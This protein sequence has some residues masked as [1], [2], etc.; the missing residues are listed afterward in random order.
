MTRK[1]VAPICYRCERSWGGGYPAAM[2]DRL[3]TQINALANAIS[4][5]AYRKEYPI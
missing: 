5:E 2:D 4:G 1:T 3:A